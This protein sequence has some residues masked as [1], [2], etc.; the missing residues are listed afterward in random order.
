MNRTD[1]HKINNIS[2]YHQSAKPESLFRNWCWATWCCDG[3]DCALFKMKCTIFMGETDIQRQQMNVER[4]KLLR[5]EVR[6]V[7]KGRGTLKNCH[8]ALRDWIR[9]VDQTYYL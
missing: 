2:Q 4:M 8:E 1:T 6:S 5:Y 9:Y 7:R 3:N